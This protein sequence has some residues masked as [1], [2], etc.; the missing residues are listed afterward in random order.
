MRGPGT[1]LPT[2]AF[3]LTSGSPKAVDG[4]PANTRD[5]AA[6]G[7]H[8]NPAYRRGGGDA[9]KEAFRAHHGIEAVDVSEVLDKVHRRRCP[10]RTITMQ[11]PAR[12]AADRP[13]RA[14]SSAL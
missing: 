3:M 8:S 11:G 10:V 5:G 7:Q 1:S 13:G 2:A 4:P 9:V 14:I 6:N 12:I